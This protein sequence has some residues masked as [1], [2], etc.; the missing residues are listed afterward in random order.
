[1]CRNRKYNVFLGL[2]SYHEKGTKNIHTEAV[3][4]PFYSLKAG[5][6]EFG[7]P[8]YKCCGAEPGELGCKRLHPCCEVKSRNL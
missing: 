8:R 2:E 3:V 5:C 1:M 6:I 4:K 7:T